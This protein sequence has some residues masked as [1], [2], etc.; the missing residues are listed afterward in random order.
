M[1]ECVKVEGRGGEGM[2][3]STGAYLVSYNC[4]FHVEKWKTLSRLNVMMGQVFNT[5]EVVS[6]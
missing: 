4:R 1:D 6:Q 2:A 5:N 3:Q